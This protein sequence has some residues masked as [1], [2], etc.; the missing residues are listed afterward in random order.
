[1]EGFTPRPAQERILA[2]ESGPMG[3]SAVPGSGKTFTLSLLAARLVDR[4][5]QSG[6][7][8]E[9]EVLV[10]TFTNS[11]VENFRNR[12]GNFLREEQGLLPGVGYR[13]RTLHGLAHD[14][15]R[16]RP[17]L[18]G[19]SES[20]DIIDERTAN[21]IKRDAVHAYLQ[22]NPDFLS[23]FI[24]PD[25][26]QNFRR[27][28]RY[29]LDDAI[30]IANATI[31]VGKE[32]RVSPH[33]LRGRLD[34]QSGSW[35]LLDFGIH[36]FADYQRSLFMRGA[37][38]F[39]DLIVLALQSL[40]ADA[41][42]LARL[43]ERWPYVLEDEA[44]DS[45]ALQ[46]QMLRLLTAQQHN[47]V[48][49]GDPNQ[50]INTTF[51]SAE[52]RFLRDFIARYPDQS[53]DLPN[54]G[55]CAIP[56]IEAANHL[57]DWS[58]HE[59]PV[60]PQSHALAPPYIAPT[61]PGD[62]Q[63]NPKGGKPAIYVF[64]RP[65]TAND[66]LNVLTSSLKRWLP[67]NSQRTVAILV[68][69]NHRGFRMVEVLQSA[70]L[71]FDDS[72][73]RSDSTTRATAKAL[74]TVL[75]YIAQPQNATHLEQL[76][77]EVWS[78]R[79]GLRIIAD[80]ATE[81]EAAEKAAREKNNEHHADRI[82]EPIDELV[83]GRVDTRLDVQVDLQVDEP[84]L[85]FSN[86]SEAGSKE[87]PVPIPEQFQTFGRAI[88]QLRETEMF[89]FPQQN[90]WIDTLSWLDKV[91]G[92][93]ELILA[94]REDVQ[95]WTQATVLPVDE[96][97]LT[98]GNDLFTEPADLALTHRLAVLL[99]KL[100]KENPDWRLPQ[101]AAELENV[102]QNRRRILGFTD[103]G[104]GYEPKP[105]HVTIATMHA[106]KGLE[107]D[108]VYLMGVNNFGFPS[109]SEDDQYGDKY[110]GERW[111]V[112]N[113]LNMVE[114]SI[115]QVR[116]LHAGSLDT[117]TLG[118]ATAQA[119]MDIAAERLRLL[120]VGITRARREL[121][122]TYNTGRNP[123]RDPNQPALAFSALMQFVR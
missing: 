22:S 103:E 115:E 83:D 8:D 21:E 50:A 100:R 32:L 110:R 87:G 31:R 98:I 25:Y 106:A 38:D 112:R 76:W 1:M 88:R 47:W 27:I 11:A 99:A 17:G 121:I 41:D 14:I 66:E 123:E 101:L 97:L 20:F 28:E 57:I 43:Q 4:L 6:R 63:P 5:A 45:S 117:F 55:R 26:L 16:E 49:V 104:L 52:T 42:F 77:S 9:R 12:I 70:K 85:L 10:V 94:F 108:R 75:S 95:R 68:P 118:P 15:V 19:L 109:G 61:P 93:R 58:M 96:L 82:L 81:A 53:R 74:A 24:Q 73:L 60:L 59:H 18:V 7:L 29:V 69:E 80:K 23:A 54:S 62:P 39:D 64:D 78:L 90:D 116:Q 84:V 113:G 56:I 92:F 65:L 37:V 122:L 34:N 72:L 71:P 91:E 67:K 51:T 119:R 30:D 13:V 111:Y 107:W 120:Y 3:V 79:I 36:I 44:Q 35:P 2:Y 89:L 105:G 86:A 102:A 46:E 33:E 40:D 48:R 114:E